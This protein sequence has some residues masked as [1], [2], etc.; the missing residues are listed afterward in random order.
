VPVNED[1]DRTES[2]IARRSG[3]SWL[4]TLLRVLS[5]VGFVLALT[6]EGS[7]RWIWLAAAV[8]LLLIPF[9]WRRKAD[10]AP[11][12]VWSASA[13]LLDGSHHFPGQLSITS[14]SVVW[15]PSHYSV[16]RGQVKL[17]LPMSDR[18]AV[19][20]RAGPAL[21][22]VLLEVGSHGRSTRFVTHRTPSL[23]RAVAELTGER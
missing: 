4:A 19:S 16:G 21:L 12:A 22:D 6:L 13:D 23:K 18:G 10:S 7:G 8:G 14:D 2:V 1:A 11:G 15:I 3:L 17:V 9:A 5:L 20:L